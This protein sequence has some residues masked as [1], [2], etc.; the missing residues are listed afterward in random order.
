MVEPADDD[1]FLDLLDTVVLDALGMI[2]DDREAR[3]AFLRRFVAL[4]QDSVRDTEH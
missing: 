2:G 3:Y 1:L 4:A